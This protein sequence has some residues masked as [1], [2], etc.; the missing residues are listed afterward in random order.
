MYPNP[1]PQRDDQP[2]YA[3]ARWSTKLYRVAKVNEQRSNAI[4]YESE[5]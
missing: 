3:A 2:A 1:T 4:G 5:A